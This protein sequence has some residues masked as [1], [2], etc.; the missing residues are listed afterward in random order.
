MC[1][2]LRRFI[3]LYRTQFKQK[4][5]SIIFKIKF[6]NGDF[7]S[8]ST[9]QIGTIDSDE[10]D[11]LCVALAHIFKYDVKSEIISQQHNSEFFSCV[12]GLPKGNVLFMFKPMNNLSK[13]KYDYIDGDDTKDFRSKLMESRKNPLTYFKYNGYTLPATM[14]LNV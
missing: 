4:H 6:D 5:F 10:F 11:N 13:T 14:N 12:S 8:C 1:D 9:V 2:E 3:C 7:R